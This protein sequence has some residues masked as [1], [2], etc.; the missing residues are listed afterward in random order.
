MDEA[1]AK[2]GNR[3]GFL[4]LLEDAEYVL[5]ELARGDAVPG[6]TLA[7]AQAFIEP[8][9]GAVFAC[10]AGRTADTV[11]ALEKQMSGLMAAVEPVTV[12]SLR[13][14]AIEENNLQ[15]ALPRWRRILRRLF[16]DSSLDLSPAVCRLSRYLWFWTIVFLVLAAAL[17]FYG[18]PAVALDIHHDLKEAARY[19]SPFF[20]GGVGGCVFLL[21]S[22]HKHVHE[23]TFD[24]RRRAEYSNRLILG[25]ISGGIILVIEPKLGTNAASISVS[26]IGFLAGYNTDLLFSAIE[27]IT[28]AVFP[29][30][31]A[32]PVKPEHGVGAA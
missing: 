21:R 32:V 3:D 25:L 29:K 26:A 1:Q 2:P 6:K 30:H 8:L 15:A 20:Y 14:T 28:N 23:R 9:T 5:V 31:S 17:T 18:N 16:M 13:D 12:M 10:R 4:K 24:R 27:R 22:L 11:A 19:L 7:A